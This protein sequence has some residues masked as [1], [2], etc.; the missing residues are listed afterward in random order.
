MS[1][2]VLEE[3]DPL[4]ERLGARRA[5]WDIDVDGDDVVNPP[6]DVVRVEIQTAGY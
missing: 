1:D 5:A 2:L 6:E 4:D 3:G